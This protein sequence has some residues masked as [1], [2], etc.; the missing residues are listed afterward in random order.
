MGKELTAEQWQAIA[1]KLAEKLAI[2]CSQFPYCDTGCRCPI[3]C[4]KHNVNKKYDGFTNQEFIEQA[5]K[6]LG[7]E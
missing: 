7:Y 4:P 2:A 3:P 5:K 6:E 1:E